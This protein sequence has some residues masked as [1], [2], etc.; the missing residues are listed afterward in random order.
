MFLSNKV[1]TFGA[2]HICF[3]PLTMIRKNQLDTSRSFIED[4]FD[5]ADIKAFTVHAFRA[6]FD[7]NRYKWN[8]SQK[9]TSEQV[10]DY[11]VRRELLF[12][13][14]ITDA[15]NNIRTIYSWKTLD[16]YTVITGLKS[17]SYLAYYTAIYLHQLSLQIPK[18]IYLN[19]EHGS[20]MPSIGHIVA[21]NSIDDENILTQ[22]SIDKAFQGSQRKSSLFYFYQDKKII[23]TN[24]KYTNKLGVVKRQSKDQ[25]FEFTDLERTLIDI[26]VRPVYAG[27]VFEVLE[28]YK[29]AKG[30]T[31][32]EKVADYLTRL[33]FIYP[34]HQVIGF[35]M[36]KAGY[37]ESDIKHFKK[38][39]NFNFYLT[40]DI[41]NKVFS[42][43]W[44]LY[45]PNG[46]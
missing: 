7:R 21:I 46:F 10:L 34:Y 22:E 24:G 12:T 1:Y 8:V 14:N 20:P 27:G 25:C 42:E 18:T 41:R 16:E 35:Y 19:V 26:S 13:N 43:K 39:M 29:R 2:K 11:L 23:L 40:Y 4:F 9:K 45:Y 5:K 37:D 17:N 44:R 31:N 28:A 30:K 3:A 36:E 38:G 6:I 33:N 15:E 32:G